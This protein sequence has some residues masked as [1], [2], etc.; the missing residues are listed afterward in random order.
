M[1]NER[2]R[3]PYTFHPIRIVDGDTPTAIRNPDRSGRDWQLA[4]HHLKGPIHAHLLR[5][6]PG[7]HDS[8]VDFAEKLGLDELILWGMSLGDDYLTAP[9]RQLVEDMSPLDDGV[10]TIPAIHLLEAWGFGS[11]TESFAEEQ[12]RLREAFQYAADYGADQTILF[13]RDYWRVTH[14]E[15]G[16]KSWSFPK[17]E[18]MLVTWPVEPVW[19]GGKLEARQLVGFHDRV[20]GL[21]ARDRQEWD[22]CQ[23]LLVTRIIIAPSSIKIWK[24]EYD[25]K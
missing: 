25:L 11:Q 23:S 14:P 20:H 5:L 12:T 10:A 24:P 18:M 3:K 1:S 9:W 13:L 7:S 19:F 16:L 21:D 15:A 4:V 2:F 6:V 8:I 22:A 17:P